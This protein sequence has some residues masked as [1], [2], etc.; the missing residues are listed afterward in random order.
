V[1]GDLHGFSALGNAE[2]GFLKDGPSWEGV[3]LFSN[4][5]EKCVLNDW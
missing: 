2:V 5:G 4:G 1:P 3:D